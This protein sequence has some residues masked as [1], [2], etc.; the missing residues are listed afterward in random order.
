METTSS[1][2]AL[3]SFTM[4]ETEGRCVDDEEVTGRCVGDE[5]VTGGRCV[6]E[7]VECPIDDFDD[8]TRLERRVSQRYHGYRNVVF[9]R[10]FIGNFVGS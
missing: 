3:V 8:D 6:G 2:P 9:G 1:D 5:E 4:E 7:E 10:S